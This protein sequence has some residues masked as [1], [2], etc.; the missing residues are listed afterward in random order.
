MYQKSILELKNISKS[1][2][3]VPVLD[4]INIDFREGEIHSI[5]GE[6]GAGKSTLIKIISGIY[7]ASSG[8]MFYDG[9]KVDVTGP[10]VA[11]EY[12]ISVVHQEIKLV[13]TQSVAENIFLGRPFTK[14]VLGVEVIAWGEIFNHA[15]TILKSINSK[16]DPRSLVRDLTIA[17]QQ[18][19]E[20]CKA[21]SKECKILI[22][23]EPT[24]SLTENEIRVLFE[25]LY[26]LREQGVT[27]IYI[28][29]RLQEVMTIS[30][31]VTVLRDG[32]LVKTSS[33]N[34]ISIDKMITL[35]V[36]RQLSDTFPQN[37]KEGRIIDEIVIEGRNLCIP[38]I[39]DNVSIKLY[40]GEILGI[41]GLVG[42]GRT[43][44]VRAL[45]GYDSIESGE[46]YVYG[47]KYSKWNYINAISNKI[48]FVSEDRAKE[49]L[50]L[51][52][53][54]R[55]NTTTCYHKWNYSGS[56][57]KLNEEKQLSKAY[58]KKLKIDATPEKRILYLSGGN[59]QKVVLSKWLAIEPEIL[60][61]DE[62]TRGIDVG[63]KFDIYNLMAEL[64]Q[65]GKSIIFISSELP[66]LIGMCDRIIVMH[67]GR[68]TG[69]VDGEKATQENIMRY[70]S[71]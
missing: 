9:N 49:G 40:K 48:G 24:A 38:G 27:I 42:A 6:N 67:E 7:K 47:K 50:I 3:G 66:E 58:I 22:M 29:H 39:L 65:Q 32:Q 60:I 59:Q 62:P 71:H 17:Q 14:K 43:E 57:L 30:D 37:P 12:G 61:L 54:V 45:F 25:I 69:E 18:I 28:S 1:F 56:L 15:Q 35:M 44:M 21:I 36:G 16:I 10:D 53:N 20:I 70:A 31:R 4:N 68:I 5:V 51:R 41:S 26:K 23:D 19:V 13:S 33:I 52:M 34:E 64:V 8:T 46:I 2:S 55:E 63:A 11:Q